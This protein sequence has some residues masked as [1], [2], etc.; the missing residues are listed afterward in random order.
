MKFSLSLEIVKNMKVLGNCK[1]IQRLK[2]KIN[3]LRI[4]FIRLRCI[5]V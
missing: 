4:T 5:G 3:K 2:N 1:Y